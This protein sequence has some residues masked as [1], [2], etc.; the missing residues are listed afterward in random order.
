MELKMQQMQFAGG[1][2][3]TRNLNIWTPILDY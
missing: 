2:F 1:K 3:W